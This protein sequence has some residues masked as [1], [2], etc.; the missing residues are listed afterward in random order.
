MFRYRSREKAK[1]ICHSPSLR[2][3]APVSNLRELPQCVDVDHEFDSRVSSPQAAFNSSAGIMFASKTSNENNAI[4]T[5]LT[6]FEVVDEGELFV[7]S[8]MKFR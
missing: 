8:L 1:A 6:D 2:N 7:A 4:R 3:A 5:I